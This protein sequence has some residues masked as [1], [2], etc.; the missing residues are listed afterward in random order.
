LVAKLNLR[1]G[2]AQPEMASKA[3][4]GESEVGVLAFL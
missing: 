4:A 3:E 1:V 2:V